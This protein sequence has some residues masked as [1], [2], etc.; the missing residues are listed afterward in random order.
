[1]AVAAEDYSL[2]FLSGL[3]FVYLMMTFEFIIRGVGDTRTPM[4]ITGL[5]LLLNAVLDP[6]FIFLLNYG[7]KGASYATILAQ[8][9]G[10]LL[11][12]LV[13][14]KKIPVLKNLTLT[15]RLNSV[16]DFF[17]QFY[18]IV[19]IGGPIGLSDA[20]FSLIYLLLSGI[21][22]VFGK[23]PLAALGIAHRIEALPFFI[24][25]GFSMA[26]APMVGQ[27]LGAGEHEKAKHSVYLSLKITVGILLGLSVLFFLFA[28]LLFDFFT[29]DPLIIAHG[30]QYLRIVAISEVF[31]ALEVVLG[32]A[33]SGAGD[34]KPPFWVVFPI[35]ALRIPIAYLLDV[36]MGVGIESDWNVIAVTTF[37]KGSLLLYW[38]RKGNWMN[39]K[40]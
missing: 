35:T 1:M 34:T 14:L 7:L 3:I 9:I 18:S 12:A 16:K 28:P 37:L 39:K 29:D 19:T 2:V 21:I 4:I 11:M 38:F 36:V 23:E 15:R 30:S 33:F 27:Y 40:V 26:V 8:A 31:L 6:V 5:S 10:A 24:C 20:G 32:G 25:L 17:A 13:L 22:S